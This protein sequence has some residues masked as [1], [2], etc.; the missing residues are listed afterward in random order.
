[1]RNRAVTDV[2]SQNERERQKDRR[3]WERVRGRE[4]EKMKTYNQAEGTVSDRN[5]LAHEHAFRRLVLLRVITFVYKTSLSRRRERA[6][7][8]AKAARSKVREREIHGGTT[9]YRKAGYFPGE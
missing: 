6:H 9:K 8:F 7:F 3:G 2:T 5:A 1:M 4:R